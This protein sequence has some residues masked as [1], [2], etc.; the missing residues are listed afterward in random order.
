MIVDTEQL[1]VCAPHIAKASQREKT[2]STVMMVIQH[3]NWPN[4][5]D[6]SLLPYYN[7]RNEHTVVDGCLLWGSRV[8]IPLVFR[9]AA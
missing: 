3:G 9:T 1:P 2:I 6:E 4:K 8:V 7:S 5:R